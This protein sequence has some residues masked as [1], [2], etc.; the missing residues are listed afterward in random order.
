MRR[1]YRERDLLPGGIERVITTES[2]LAGTVA[3]IM[4]DT[5][6]DGGILVR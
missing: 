6:L 4:A 2:S 5:G 3:T 1:W